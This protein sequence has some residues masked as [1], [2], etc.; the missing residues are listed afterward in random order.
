MKKI[1]ISQHRKKVNGAPIL[2]GKEDKIEEI[3]SK[4][5][6]D[7]SKIH[8]LVNPKEDKIWGYISSNDQDRSAPDWEGNLLFSEI[9]NNDLSKLSQKEAKFIKEL[10][11]HLLEIKKGIKEFEISF[12]EV[13]IEF[14][15]NVERGTIPS[16]SF[17]LF[18]EQ[19][20]NALVFYEL[21]LPNNTSESFVQYILPQKINENSREYIINNFSPFEILK[22][23]EISDSQ[24]DIL[25][26]AKEVI[27]KIKILQYVKEENINELDTFSAQM[28]YLRH[29]KTNRLFEKETALLLFNADSNDF[30]KIS[31]YA[32]VDVTKKT[33][34]LIHGT[35]S[36]TEGTFGDLFG[37]STWL[38][39][40]VEDGLY[41]QII[42]F[43]HPTV[44]NDAATNVEILMNY[45]SG[46]KFI[47]PV[48]M[49]GSSQGGL[50]CQYIANYTNA[51]NPFKAGKITLIASANGVEYLTA[52]EHVGTFLNALKFVAELTGNL[53]GT[54]IASLAQMTI[55]T[56]I[57]LPGID[58]MNPNSDRLKNIITNKPYSNTTVY[59]P[60]IDDFSKD[61]VQNKKIITRIAAQALDS[62]ISHILGDFNDWVV[63]TKNQYLVPADYCVIQDY[64]PNNFQ[65]YM[66]PAIH[67]T[68]L[69]KNI[70]KS[71]IKSFFFDTL[72][73]R[74]NPP[75]ITAYDAHCHI[76]T[77]KYALRELPAMLYS[78]T[79]SE[80][81]E[82]KDRSA[83][84]ASVK[85]K[86]K[87]IIEFLQAALGSEE[88]NLRFIQNALSYQWDV[89]AGTV[90]AVPLMM[91][92]QYM[93]NDPLEEDT[94]LTKML[95]TKKDV[96]KTDHAYIKK[97]IEE[98]LHEII[99]SFVDDH[100][101]HPKMD[102][103]RK[104]IDEFLLDFKNID[105]S[106]EMNVTLLKKSNN[107]INFTWGFKT[108]F[109]NLQRMVEDGKP[110][111]PFFAV[112]PRRQGVVDAI[113]KDGLIGKD[114][115][116]YGVK[117]YPRL[118]CHPK[119]EPMREVLA[120]CLEKNYPVVT[121]CSA[122]G[123]PPQN[124]GMHGNDTWPYADYCDPE[125][126]RE[127]VEKGLRINFA[128]FGNYD[129][130]GKWAKTIVE[131]IDKYP[132]V[133]T[134]LSCYKMLGKLQTINEDFFEHHPALKNRTLY[135]SDFD[136]IYF[137]KDSI[138]LEDYCNNFMLTFDN[139]TLSK[140]RK[141]NV[142]KFLFYFDEATHNLNNKG[143]NKKLAPII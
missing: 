37:S 132:N 1:D 74:V 110:I 122:E 6:K 135:G 71:E 121:H 11:P 31:D 27:V 142:E 42:A 4:A 106:N 113:R 108:H 22:S 127:F 63:G 70:V 101:D 124:F 129:K 95:A 102:E 35:F 137:G 46:R 115:P 3:V 105:I 69:K 134:D 8:E 85:K 91:D 143:K 82:K 140:M 83:R 45:F 58:V 73:L 119:S 21:T 30:N 41:Q 16:F 138:T 25:K 36:T 53:C 103:A 17:T 116:F 126:F 67:G 20:E 128:H 79:F 66:I 68:C 141:D 72:H 57:R 52:A 109:E 80:S 93:F 133:F 90:G 65:P 13:K 47:E 29:E 50:L 28:N 62:I 60:V 139:V 49:M 96:S 94:S 99:S 59:F 92:I 12:E 23:R 118:G 88:R 75:E 130:S 107:Q 81:D 26:K 15:D 77:L 136:M 9:A 54:L 111:Y 5:S 55:E 38:K 33:L 123:F 43:D 44:Y 97:E 19:H 7:F 2:L 34:L 89:N 87:Q 100:R 40:L 24:S 39:S 32:T 10:N 112:D 104:V 98:D 76:F 56:I 78:L 120:I 114:G 125:H 131:Y 64:D 84:K 117:L 51:N 18:A 61:I 86:L 48:D 14:P